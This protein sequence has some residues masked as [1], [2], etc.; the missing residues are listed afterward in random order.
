MIDEAGYGER[1]GHGLGHGVGLVVHEAP[2]LRPES[3][4]CSSR[5]TSSRVEPGIYLSGAPACGSRI[6]SSSARTAP[7]C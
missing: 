2:T 6:S 4:D 1:F 7:R 5:A 3:S